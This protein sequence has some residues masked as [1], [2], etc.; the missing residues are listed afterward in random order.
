MAGF[1]LGKM[2]LAG[3]FKKPE[4]LMYPLETKTPPA[5]LKG[6]VENEVNACIL[7]G[8]C[9]KRCPCGAIDVDKAAR[10]WAIDR[11]RCVQCGNCVRECPKN[12]L[13]M[14]PAY[15]SAS[16]KKYVDS[17]DVPEA[18]KVSGNGNTVED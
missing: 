16:T 6:H 13:T 3:L 10:V 17:F 12:C 7:C 8:I 11:F 4:T 15:A 1:K 9:M 2:T 18:N 5:G 14:D